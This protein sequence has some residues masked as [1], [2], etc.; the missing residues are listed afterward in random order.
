M[1]LHHKICHVLGGSFELRHTETHAVMLPHVVAYN[2]A[3]ALAAMER[4]E[5]ALSQPDAVAG[6]FASIGRWAILFRSPSSACLTRDRASRRA[7]HER[8]VFEPST[9]RGGRIAF[10]ACESMVR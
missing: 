8:S 7:G 6:L 3:A 5:N 2:S 1:G 4:V 10:D 9:A